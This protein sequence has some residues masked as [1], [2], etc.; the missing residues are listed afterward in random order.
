MVVCLPFKYWLTSYP[1]HY[2]AGRDFLACRLARGRNR[3]RLFVFSFFIF[4]VCFLNTHYN[5][6]DLPPNMCVFFLQNSF[7]CSIRIRHEIM[8]LVDSVY[9]SGHGYWDG[10]GCHCNN[11]WTGDRCESKLILTELFTI[12]NWRQSIVN[13]FLPVIMKHTYLRP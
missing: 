5:Y 3:S 1:I 6:S 12:I 13:T 4:S 10:H 11:G 2:R 7:S 9:C 8:A